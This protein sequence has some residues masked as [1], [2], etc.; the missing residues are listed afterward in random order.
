[1]TVTVDPGI[2]FSMTTLAVAEVEVL[3]T[4]KAVLPTTFAEGELSLFNRSSRVVALPPGARFRDPTSGLE[5]EA[6]SGGWLDPQASALV[7]I[8]ALDPGPQGNLPAGR[9]RE[10][11]GPAPD[12]LEVSQGSYTS[13]GLSAARATVG[14]TDIATLRAQ[15][16]E[17]IA[18]RIRQMLESAASAQGAMLVDE[19]LLIVSQEE[20]LSATVG[21]AVDA[22]RMTITARAESLAVPRETVLA[23]MRQALSIPEA[24][25]LPEAEDLRVERDP[26]GSLYIRF[27]SQESK[28]PIPADLA[29][30]LA[31]RTPAGAQRVVASLLPQSQATIHLEP[32]WWPLLPI[33]PFR[34]HVSSPPL[35]QSP[36]AL[37]T[38]ARMAH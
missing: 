13:G 24:A 32:A 19:S 28:T 4:A 11:L 1:M 21:T 17:L 10:A 7:A 36:Q 18:E 38:L 5:F 16:R 3:S 25:G 6:L 15:G 23:R 31:G 29:R 2:P 30:H 20:S 9:I 14:A 12:T 37:R 35:S 27:S 26:Q 33:F 22:V 34:I 8:R